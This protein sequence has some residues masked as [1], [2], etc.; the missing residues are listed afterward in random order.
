M[1]EPQAK[2]RRAVLCD[3]Y[4]VKEEP[5]RLP[6]PIGIE[7]LEDNAEDAVREKA[8]SSRF[9]FGSCSVCDRSSLVIYSCENCADA[10]CC[11]CVV[12]H[13]CRDNR[14]APCCV[15]CLTCTDWHLCA[16]NAGLP[17]CLPCNACRLDRLRNSNQRP[18][19]L[20][21]WNKETRTCEIC[22]D[23]KPADVAHILGFRLCFACGKMACQS[24]CR[25]AH[26]RQILC[27]PCELLRESDRT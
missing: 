9:R 2:R 15:H 12:W 11:A 13:L 7:L 27:T 21:A 8:A 17:S 5:M 4:D 24:H 25:L 26:D 16:A 20:R 23:T 10:V 19:Q 18:G 6:R 22:H 3:V 1:G 14:W